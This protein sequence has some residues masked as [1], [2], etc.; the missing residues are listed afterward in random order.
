MADAQWLATLTR[1]GLLRASF[2]PPLLMRQLRLVAR[3][4]QKLVGMYSA[5][6]N[7]LYKVLVDAGI[8]INMVVADIHGASARAMIKSLIADAP[9]RVRAGGRSHALCVEGQVRCT[10]H[11]QGPQEIGHCAGA[12]DAAKARLHSHAKRI[13]IAHAQPR[14]WQRLASGQGS[15][16]PV[17]GVFHIQRLPSAHPLSA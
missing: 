12:Q 10:G 8:R 17:G 3:Q 13:L 11:P 2:I 5:E 16:S 15:V 9:V 6:K 7:L 4:R 14:S 1:A